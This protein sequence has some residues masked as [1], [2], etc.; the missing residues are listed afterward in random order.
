[1]EIEVVDLFRNSSLGAIPI[2]AVSSPFHYQNTKHET[3][4]AAHPEEATRIALETLWCIFLYKS[5]QMKISEESKEN[6]CKSVSPVK[7]SIREPSED[8]QQVAR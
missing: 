6:Q 4:V 1:L 3:A 5:Q 7:T 8:Q 2:F